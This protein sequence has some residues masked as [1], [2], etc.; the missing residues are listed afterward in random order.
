MKNHIFQHFN[1]IFNSISVQCL[2]YDSLIP[3]FGDIYFN[4][5]IKLQSTQNTNRT[6]QFHRRTAILIWLWSLFFI[7]SIPSIQFIFLNE[8]FSSVPS[9]L[10]RY[11]RFS[12]VS[13]I[14]VFILSERWEQFCCIHPKHKMYKID[15][16]KRK[17]LIP[18]YYFK[19]S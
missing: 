9:F 4:Y 5:S 1:R 16:I 15:E 10:I 18:I 2:F 6:F 19:K 13:V 12:G 14:C 11:I 7:Q 3:I 8:H 17:R